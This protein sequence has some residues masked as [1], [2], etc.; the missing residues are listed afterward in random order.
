MHIVADGLLY[1]TSGTHTRLVLPK[2]WHRKLY[3]ELHENMGHLGADRV[4]DL[5]R[6]RFYWPF[7]RTDITHYVNNVCHCL[8]QR[9]PTTHTRAP[10]QPINSTAPFQL[11]SLDFVHLEPSSGGYQ[12][13]LAIMDH[14][15]RFAQAYATRDKSAKTAA[16]KLFN[17]FILRFGFPETI[18]HDQGREFENKLFYNLEKLCGIKHSRTTPYHPQGNGQVERFNRTLLSM[19]RAL[20]ELQKSR[21]R[22]HLNKVVHAYNCT[23]NDAT[24]FPPFYLVFGRLS[25]LPIDI[26]FGLKPPTSTYP[27][28]VKQWRSAMDKAY[29]LA[30]TNASKSTATSKNQYDKKVRHAVLQEGDR[31]L[32]RNLSE[33]NGP[34][35]LR[36]YWEDI[37]VVVRQK[38]D[39]PVYVVQPEKGNGS[40]LPME[41][42]SVPKALEEFCNMVDRNT[43]CIDDEQP[44]R[45]TIPCEQPAEEV[46]NTDEPVVP[47]LRRSGR[48]IWPTQRL[49]YDVGG[50]PVARVYGIW[51]PT[52]TQLPQQWIPQSIVQPWLLPPQPIYL[53]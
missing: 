6:E 19:L 26:M 17:D 40:F 53:F 51:Q 15:T 30:S 4:I 44:L 7:M 21:W 18:H 48:V 24:G 45:G 31:V 3:Q 9:K 38:G 50:H 27:E 13:I 46:A 20:P 47:A 52:Q 16:D 35:K 22:D 36:S 43:R 12:Y 1:H 49:T 14:Y 34:G 42:Q 10:L 37:H 5:A 41:E 8:N 33:R 23:R 25:R 29:E 39:M 2:Q 11:V 28:Y 32:V